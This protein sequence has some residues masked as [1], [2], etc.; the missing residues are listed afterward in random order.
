MALSPFT[1]RSSLLACL[2]AATTATSSGTPDPT[3]IVLQNGRS[4][5]LTSLTL[6]GDNLVVQSDIGM[7]KAGQA[8]PLQ[9]ADHVF[10]EKPAAINEAVAF[11]LTGK[12]QDAQRLLDSVVSE[13]RITAK[14]PGNF[15]IEAARTLLI[16]R[17]LVADAPGCVELGKEITEATPA[18]GTDSFVTLGRALLMPPTIKLDDRLAALRDLSTGKLPANVSAYA[19]FFRANLLKKEKRTPEALEAFLS[20]PCLFPSGGLI[21]NAAAEIQA[22][23]FLNAEGRRE[24]AIALLTSA[25]REAAG[26]FLVN[27]ANKRLDSLK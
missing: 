27:D 24:E 13:L 20:V 25:V 16:A 26:T 18:Q 14:I 19:A 6:Q 21:L 3:Q 23:D 7:F 11:L 4:I 12:P 2:C 22:A 17:A 8:I 10:G 5:P 15:W 9:S 1:L